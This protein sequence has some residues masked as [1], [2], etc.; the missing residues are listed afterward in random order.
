MLVI[1]RKEGEEIII[2]S[3]DAPIGIIRF[4]CIKSGYVKV[5]LD[6]PKDIQ[7]NRAEL[8]NEDDEQQHT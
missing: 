2:G 5:A 7:V 8:L 4:V 3:K 1:S 6:F